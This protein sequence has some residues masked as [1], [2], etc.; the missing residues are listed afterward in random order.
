MQDG[1]TNIGHNFFFFQGC[2]DLGGGVETQVLHSRNQLDPAGVSNAAALSS[3]HI[4]LAFFL[5]NLSQLQ[6]ARNHVFNTLLQILLKEKHFV[7]KSVIHQMKLHW[8]ES[9]YNYLIL[10]KKATQSSDYLLW[11][12]VS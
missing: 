6:N 5:K 3:P 4:V 8:L 12:K 2:Q 7:L 9:S 1:C 10:I 11:L